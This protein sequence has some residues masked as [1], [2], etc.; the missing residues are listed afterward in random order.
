MVVGSSVNPHLTGVKIKGRIIN[1]TALARENIE[2]EI[3]IAGKTKKF[4]INR[5]SSGNSTGFEVYVP[6]V[7]IDKVNIAKFEKISSYALY[8]Y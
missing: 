1:S 2:F 6:D 5:I 4:S 8:S 7:P 3:T